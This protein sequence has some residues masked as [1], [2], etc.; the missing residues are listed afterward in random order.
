M[1]NGWN[2][3]FD[4]EI[5][6]ARHW[7][8]KPLLIRSALENFHPPLDRH[9]LAGLALEQGVESRI[10]EHRD[11]LWQLHHGPFSEQDFQRD[12]PWSLLVQAVDHHIPEVAALRQLFS[13]LPQWRMDDVM[14]SYAVD[15]GSVGPHY[16]N[17]DVFLLQGEG[18]RLWKLGQ[19]CDVTSTLLPH[20]ELRILD[21][22]ECE[23]EY[24]LGPGD[25]LYV[26][27]GVA[28]WGIAQGEC[29]TFSVGFRAPRINDM[30]SRWVDQLLEQL[31]SDQF[32]SDAGQAPVTRPGEIRPRDLDRAL[33]QLQAALDQDAGNHWF[34]ELVTEP[35]YE[36]SWDNDDLAE[37]R[38][39]LADGATFV[40]LSPAAKLCWQQEPEGIAVFANGESLEFAQG[41]RPVLITLC[42]SW[43][44]QGDT[45]SGVMLDP[46]SAALLNYLLESGCIYVE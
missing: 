42:D 21:T 4:P 39:L 16:D 37:A 18:E 5:F 46:D 20:D 32:Y 40:E 10:I 45:L 2:Q 14:V 24:L 29:T 33:A 17:Y 26:P 22:F 12:F 19:F 9:E 31:D 3:N 7:Q 15:G 8:R 11:G 1:S 27:P 41:V 6:L 30:V 43:R 35:R 44:L 38:A 13:F 36:P 23:Q 34:G 28:H 25:M